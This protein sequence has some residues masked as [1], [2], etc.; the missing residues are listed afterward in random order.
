MAFNSGEFAS[1]SGTNPVELTDLIVSVAA[2]AMLLWGAWVIV[3]AF[4][5]WM[6]GSSDFYDFM[7]STLRAA[8]VIMILGYFIRPEANG[9]TTFSS[10]VRDTLQEIGLIMGLFVSVAGMVLFAWAAI[11]KFNDARSGKAEWGEVGVL[12]IAGAA[13]LMFIGY[14]LKIA[15]TVFA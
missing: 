2:G 7:W 13:M 11:A 12:G 15:S 3:S 14:L 4:R 5:A 1:G 6:D 10:M 8:G 9:T